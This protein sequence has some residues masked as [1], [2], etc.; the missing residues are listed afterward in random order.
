[1]PFANL[2]RLSYAA[3]SYCKD[4]ITHKVKAY[5]SGKLH[6]FIKVA[7]NCFFNVLAK[8]FEALTVGM[9]AIPK[10]L[11][12]YPPS[13]SSSI[14]SNIISDMVLNMEDFFTV[15]K[16]AVIV[17][18]LGLEFVKNGVSDL[19]RMSGGVDFLQLAY[20][21]LRVNLRR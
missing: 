11:A 5:Y 12:E 1:M 8:L 2:L 4:F 10:A 13:I 17:F 21:N 7:F 15:C 20:G 6:R 18:D 16:L 19:G 3:T 14:T 9:D